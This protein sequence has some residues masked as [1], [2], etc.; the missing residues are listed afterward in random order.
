MCSRCK[1]IKYPFQKGDKRNHARDVCSD[2]VGS[3]TSIPY[4]QH[5]RLFVNNVLDLDQLG[6]R[7]A[8]ALQLSHKIKMGT[9]SDIPVE[10]DVNLVQ[11]LD[12]RIVKDG[13]R[14]LVNLSG[15]MFKETGLPVDEGLVLEYDGSKMFSLAVLTD[16]TASES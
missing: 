14:T 4:P 8:S 6:E 3:T 12:P 1:K 13:P 5:E 10:H 11:F 16:E 15:I 7:I 2:G 9:C